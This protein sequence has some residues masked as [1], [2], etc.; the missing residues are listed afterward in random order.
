MLHNFLRRVET[1]FV[2]LNQR[3]EGLPLVEIFVAE[4]V[5]FEGEASDWTELICICRARVANHEVFTATL[6][7]ELLVA[8]LVATWALVAIVTTHWP[9]HIS[10]GKLALLTTVTNTIESV[11]DHGC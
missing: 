5:Y 2:A 7:K 6:V 4:V 1:S 9:L 10:E 3:I 8:G 11:E